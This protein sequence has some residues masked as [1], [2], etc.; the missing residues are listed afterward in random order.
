MGGWQSCLPPTRKAKPKP[1]NP[2]DNLSDAELL[3]VGEVADLLKRHN[4]HHEFSYDDH[5][6]LQAKEARLVIDA[7]LATLSHEQAAELWKMYA[8]A[9]FGRYRRP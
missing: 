2:L 6:L 7:A 4:W 9:S 1:S 5:D 3:K 8:P